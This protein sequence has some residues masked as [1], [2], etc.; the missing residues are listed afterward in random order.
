MQVWVYRV[1]SKINNAKEIEQ[2]LRNQYDLDNINELGLNGFY[3]LHDAVI[4]GYIDIVNALINAK[5]DK[6]IREWTG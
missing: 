1:C 2:Y 5:A 6:N 3:P 4:K